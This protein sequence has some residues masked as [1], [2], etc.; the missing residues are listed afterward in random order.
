VGSKSIRLS[1]VKFKYEGEFKLF[2]QF[3]LQYYKK[4]RNIFKKPHL[5][6]SNMKFVTL[7]LFSTKKYQSFSRKAIQK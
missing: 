5:Y 2:L 4:N 1:E 3:S 6:P 7:A